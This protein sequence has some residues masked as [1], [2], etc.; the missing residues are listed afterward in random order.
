MSSSG[1]DPG[2][3]SGNPPYA[4]Y[5]RFDSFREYE[6]LL[7]QLIPRTQRIIRV[8]D[9][10]LSRHYNAVTRIDSLE[11][12][13]RAD[14]ANR[15]TIIL[16]DSSTVAT[17]CPRFMDLLRGHYRSIT[18]RQTLQRVRHA[19]DPFVTFDGNHYL[20]RFHFDHMRSAIGEDDV[21]G[22]QQLVD[23]FNEL[24][25]YASPPMGTNVTGL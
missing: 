16:H 24:A 25:E 8:F 19:H 2:A 20:H 9:K 4:R 1:H 22:C 23:R 15:L 11:H 17:Q 10:V 12:F 7:D 14:P 18:V 3:Q 21:V 6:E 5:R 13:I